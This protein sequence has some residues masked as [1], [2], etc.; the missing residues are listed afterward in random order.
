MRAFYGEP[1]R[2]DGA[3]YDVKLSPDEKTITVRELVG[4]KG[5]RL[6]IDHGS[7]SIVLAGKKYTLWIDDADRKPIDVPADEYTV[8]SYTQQGPTRPP[9]LLCG[10]GAAFEIVPGKLTELA[11]GTPLVGWV[12]ISQSRGKV[13]FQPYL[14]DASGTPVDSMWVALGE[15]R[16]GMPP[17][18]K[19]NVRDATGK[20]VHAA[21]MEPG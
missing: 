19:I 20:I 10:R 9:I 6:K 7:Y 3:W 8:L 21:E 17:P 11:I 12:R 1:I 4:F 15:K 2:I 18:P 14:K 16:W 5:G 13:T